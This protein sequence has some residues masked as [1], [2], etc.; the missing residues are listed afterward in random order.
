M[1]CSVTV[2]EYNCGKLCEHLSDT[3]NKQLAGLCSSTNQNENRGSRNG[4]CVNTCDGEQFGCSFLF[5]HLASEGT[6][7][8]MF[9]K[10]QIEPASTHWKLYLAKGYRFMLLR[11]PKALF[12]LSTL[13]KIIHQWC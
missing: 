2:P 6:Q 12:S 13:S 11:F 1:F 5:V 8:N 3:V 7:E 10:V 9:S 4:K